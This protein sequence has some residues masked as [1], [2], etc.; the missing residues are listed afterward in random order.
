MFGGFEAAKVFNDDK[1]N[2]VLALTVVFIKS[3]LSLGMYVKWK[4]VC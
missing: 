1:N 3:L 2:A 4:I